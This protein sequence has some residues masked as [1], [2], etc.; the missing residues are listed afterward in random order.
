MV[1][2]ILVT[3]ALMLLTQI[4]L[5]LIIMVSVMPVNKFAPLLTAMTI[6]L[7]RPMRAIFQRGL[8]QTLR[9]RPARRVKFA[10]RRR[11]SVAPAEMVSLT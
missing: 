2:A 7:A 5:T 8:A 10:I 3:T 6:M 9:R 11:D 1:K 4:N